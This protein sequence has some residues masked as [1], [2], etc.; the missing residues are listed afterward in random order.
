M[1]TSPALTAR[2]FAAPLAVCLIVLSACT[3]ITLGEL[4]GDLNSLTSARVA[5]PKPDSPL[6]VMQGQSLQEQYGALSAKRVKKAADLDG[7][8]KVFALYIATVASYYAQD[9]SLVSGANNALD[10]CQK[11]AVKQPAQG[12]TVRATQAMGAI[13]QLQTLTKKNAAA[14]PGIGW[15][16]T[17]NTPAYAGGA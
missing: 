9:S 5:A 7:P 11:S 10:A 14:H 13:A 3:R 2:K 4:R 6:D 1:T 8:D 15:A 17:M 12:M 16:A